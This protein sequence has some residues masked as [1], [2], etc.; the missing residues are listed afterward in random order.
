MSRSMVSWLLSALS[1]LGSLPG[2]FGFTAKAKPAWDLYAKMLVQQPL[3]T[4]SLTSCCTNSISDVICQKTLP[5]REE[6]AKKFDFTRLL[7]VAVTGIVWSGPITHYWYKLLFGKM[8]GPIDDPLIRL[9]V[10]IFLDAIIFSPVTVSGYFTVRSFLEGS[11][12]AGAW[13][14]LRTRLVTAV[15]GAWKFWPA[16]N[17]INFSVVP[18]A[19]RVLY[20]NVLSIFWQGF[21]TYVN[22]QKIKKE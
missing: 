18:I 11:G 4:K 1:A 3:L 7:H 19:Y 6:D 2:V 13:E 16:V 9:M 14:K 20:N 15:L 12:T 8:T 21:L 17:V 5:A 10:R 22:S